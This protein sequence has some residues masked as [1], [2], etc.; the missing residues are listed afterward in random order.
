MTSVT[1]LMRHNPSTPGNDRKWL[2]TRVTAKLIED[3]SAAVQVLASSN[4]LL[5]STPEV[6]TALR[7]KHSKPPT[8]SRLTQVQ[9]YHS[10]IATYKEIVIAA[11]K[12][13]SG[14]SSG[15][16]ARP[17]HIKNLSALTDQAGKR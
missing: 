10:S 4:T 15:V 17:G 11:L 9:D 14:S 6:L 5:L 16:D 7:L 13:F 12:S 3:V 2:R 8:D 1:A